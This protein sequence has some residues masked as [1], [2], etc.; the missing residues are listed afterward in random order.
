MDLAL[1]DWYKPSV[2]RKKLKEISKRKDWP[3]LVHFFIYFV[4]LFV[5]GYFA[6]LTWGT[7]WTILWFFLYG[8]IFQF[9]VSNWHETVHRTAFKTRWINEVFYHISC[10]MADMEPFRWRW[11]HT[12]HH[13]NTLQ[14]KDDYD[15]E[16]QVSRPTELIW[17]FLNFVPLSDLLYPHRLLKFEILKHA[18]GYLTPVVTIAA[19][20]SQKKNIIWTSRLYVLIWIAVIIVSIVYSTI[21][22]ILF[23]IIPNYY[24]KPI[25]FTVNVTQHLAAAID[26]K[27]HRQSAYT[28]KI[29]PILSFLY[30]HM[31]YHLEHHMFPMVPSYNL[32][33]LHNL[34]KDEIPKPFSSLWAFHRTVMPA[35]IKMATNP[36]LHYKTNI[37]NRT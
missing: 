6:Y 10:F 26:K 15:Y 22:P 18:F 30:W 35:V 29:N 34:I 2:D 12:F 37:P 5:C 28:V 33:K 20:D 11:S 7:L 4:S 3:G 8:S 23:I 21:V 32:H 13:T 16:I 19:P 1:E 31:E 17:F 36:E 9:S 27:D 25:W 14:T 24:G